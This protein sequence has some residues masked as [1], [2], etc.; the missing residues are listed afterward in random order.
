MKSQST[1]W[2]GV[3]RF[4]YGWGLPVRWQ[5]WVALAAYFVLLLGGFYYFEPRGND[6]GLFVYFVVLSA[7]MVVLI[8]LKGERPLR[9]RWGEK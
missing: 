3:K 9:W 1:F 6:L 8:V 4:G 2:F 5:G 7:A